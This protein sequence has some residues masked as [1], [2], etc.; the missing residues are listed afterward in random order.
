[1][2]TINLLGKSQR[3]LDLEWEINEM[4]SAKKGWALW[5]WE[6]EVRK[7]ERLPYCISGESDRGAVRYLFSQVI[8]EM[9]GPT[10]ET[11]EVEG[12]FRSQDD[13][14]VVVGDEEFDSRGVLLEKGNPFH[15]E[16]LYGLISLAIQASKMPSPADAEAYRARLV[17]AV[18]FGRKKRRAANRTFASVV[19]KVLPKEKDQGK[20]KDFQKAL[21]SVDFPFAGK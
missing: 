3:G 4:L 5:R 1:L 13:I 21:K 10:G 7:Y 8:L 17:E 18:R 16:N 19:K 15:P 20:N 2:I 6:F 12:T 14:C 9:T 11:V